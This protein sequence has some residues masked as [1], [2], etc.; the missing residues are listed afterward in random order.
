MKQDAFA[1]DL[2]FADYE[3]L[4]DASE[5]VAHKRGNDVQWYVTKLP[6]GVWAAWDDAELSLDRVEYA[7]NK[8]GALS[9]VYDALATAGYDLGDAPVVDRYRV[10]AEKVGEHWLVKAYGY[11]YLSSYRCTDAE[12][13]I[14]EVLNGAGEYDVFCECE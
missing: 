5:V 10:S 1:R 12:D 7:E 4:L 6:D 13:A 8:I 9:Y 11:Q 3:T 14:R 2:G